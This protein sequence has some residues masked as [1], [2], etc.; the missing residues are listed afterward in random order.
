MKGYP[1]YF[2]EGL[3]VS[4]FIRLCRLFSNGMKRVEAEFDPEHEMQQAF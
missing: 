2:R 3:L 4:Q 1:I